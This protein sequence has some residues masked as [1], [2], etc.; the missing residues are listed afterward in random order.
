MTP[1][2][3]IAPA[4]LAGV[5]LLRTQTDER[6]VDLVRAGNDGAFEAI[7]SRYRGPLLRY[8]CALL[9]VARAEDAVQQTF[10]RAYDSLRASDAEMQLR[11]WLYRIAHNS[12]LNA[13]R[14]RALGHGQLS[15]QID[16]VERPDQAYE[17]SQSLREVVAAV[18][19]LPDRQRHAI[20]LRELEGRSYDE[21][22]V[23]LGASNGAV[24]QLLN[25]A[26]LTLR[27]G[28]TAITPL[29]LL[30]RIPWTPGPG[31]DTAVR[32][33]EICGGSAGGAVL[34]KVCATALVTGAVLG[35]A[36]TVPGGGDGSKARPKTSGRA[37]LPAGHGERR[38]QTSMTGARA[39]RH[40]EP[41]ARHDQVGRSA[42]GRN[43]A[44]DSK[45]GADDDDLA[46]RSERDEDHGPGSASGESDSGS[47]ES[48]SGS[49]GSESG[50]GESASSSGSG[51][52][53]SGSSGS[54][55]LEP[56]LADSE[57]SGSGT[58]S[59]PLDGLETSGSTSGG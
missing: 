11:P 36:A 18:K 19:L 13:L 52:G 28:A 14:D 30:T 6:L 37:T 41:G 16:G 48:G 50:S 7:V 40:S 15:E 49:E 47:G 29:A 39:D 17:R 33:A 25:R 32:V 23:S 5:S 46:D 2:A 53:E 34:A 44:G 8:C 22:A 31:G 55:S 42:N 51:S 58:S 54:G 38:G 27:A 9:P 43:G 10:L 24:R 12:T 56:D 21:I 45:G 4:R 59:S 35:G 3:L 20:V 1:N 57:P 26:R